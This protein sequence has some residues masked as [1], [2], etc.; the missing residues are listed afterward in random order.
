MDTVHNVLRGKQKYH[1]KSF[2]DP[3]PQISAAPTEA[4]TMGLSPHVCAVCG[5]LSLRPLSTYLREVGPT[6]VFL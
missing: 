1:R 2:T 4:K 3:C 5:Y 6:R